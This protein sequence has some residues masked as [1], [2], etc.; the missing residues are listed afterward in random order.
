MSKHKKVMSLNL[1][2]N[3]DRELID[4]VG[5]LKRIKEIVPSIN[6]DSPEVSAI[7]HNLIQLKKISEA[8]LHEKVHNNNKFIQ[9]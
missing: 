2:S 1:P 6:A 9:K 5:L 8:K 7:N 4:P 3:R